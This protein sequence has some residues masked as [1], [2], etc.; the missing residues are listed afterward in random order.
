MAQKLGGQWAQEV[1]GDHN[2]IVRQQV[3]SHGG[4]EVKSQ[5]GRLYDCLLQRSTRPPMCHRHPACL[6]RLRWAAS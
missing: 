5:G 3:A 1:L 4:F 6:A 2:T